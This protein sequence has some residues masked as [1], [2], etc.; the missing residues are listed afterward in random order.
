MVFAL[1]FVCVNT[2]L[3]QSRDLPVWLE[4]ELR[5]EA[6]SLS[7]QRVSA[8]G[9]SQQAESHRGPDRHSGPL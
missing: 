3:D 9:E 7:R 6:Q 4:D 8:G 5:C 2:M 1:M